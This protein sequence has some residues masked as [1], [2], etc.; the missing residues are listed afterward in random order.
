[1]TSL[2]Q[3]SGGLSLSPIRRR[4]ILD[5]CTR[6]DLP[7]SDVVAHH[8][9]YVQVSTPL[10]PGST[11]RL[12]ALIAADSRV[13]RAVQTAEQGDHAA[14]ARDALVVKVVPRPGTISPWS[15]KATDILHACGVIEVNRIERGTCYKIIPQRGWLTDKKLQDSQLKMLAGLLH[16]RMSES[17]FDH[18]FNGEALF[19]GRTGQPLQQLEFLTK[20]REALVH[21]N[22]AWALGLADEEIAHLADAYGRLNRNPTDVELIMFAQANSE[23]CRHKIFNAQWRIDGMEQR[24]SLFDMIRA[25]HRA[26]PKGTVVAY[27]DNAAVMEGG[28]VQRFSAAQASHSSAYAHQEAVEHTLMKVETHNH[29]TAIAPYPGAATGAGGEIRDEGATGR[30]ASPRV[31]L[32]GFT[33]SHLNLPQRTEP[34]E[35]GGLGYPAHTVDALTILREGS[36]GGAAYNNEFGRP[37]VLGY[38]RSFEQQIDG[39]NWGYHKPIMLA[40]GMGAIDSTQTHKNPIREG[41]LLIQIG[42]PG[43]RIGMGGG[44]ASSQSSG[45]TADQALDFD[46]VQ[47]E[48][49]ELQRR[50]QELI[51]RCW[52][53]GEANPIIAIHDVG[54][55]GLSNAFPEL[56]HDAGMGAIFDLALVP[57]AETGLSPAEVWSNEAQE[58]YVLAVAPQDIKRFDKLARRERCPYAVIGVATKEQQLRVTI[59]EGLPGLPDP[60][61]GPASERFRN[62]SL[63]DTGVRP[64]DLP[65]DVI[66]GDTPGL[67]MEA[68]SALA[69]NAHMDL[70]AIDLDEA[71]FRVLR[72]PTVASKSFLITG[73]D[74]TAGAFTARDQMVGPW[75]V[76]VADCAVGTADYASLRGQAMAMGERTPLAILNAPA[77]GR[78]AVAEALTNLAAADVRSMADIKLSANWMAAC[79]MPGQDAALYATVEAVSQWCQELGLSIP[80]GK[81]S[82]SMRLAWQNEGNE[83]SVQSPVSLVVTAFARVADVSRTLTPQLRTDAGDTVL[84]LIDLGQ[85]HQRLAGS[86]LMHAFEQLGD[87]TPDISVA[88]PLLSFFSTIRQLVDQE[89][90]L[91]YHDRSDGGLLA[92]VAEMAFAGRTGVSLNLDMLTFDP[93]VSDWGDYK[94][95]ANQVSVQRHEHT[96]KALFNEEAGAVLQV[97]RSRRDAVL[98]HLRQ[99]GLSTC[100]HV[101]GTLNENHEFQVYRDGQCLVRHPM[102]DLAQHWGQLSCDMAA[103]DGNPDAAKQEFERWKQDDAGLYSKLTF[104]P[105]ENIFAPFVGQGTRPRVGIL[106]EQGSNG[107]VEMAWAFDQAGFEAVDIHMSDLI[108]GNVQ[109]DS[110]KGLAVVGGFSWGDVFGA[111]QAWAQI[112]L[113]HPALKEQ[114]AAYFDREDTFALGVCNGAQMLSGLAGIIPGSSHW[115]RFVRNASQRYEA[116]LSMVGVAPSPSLF[117]TDMQGS[118][119]PVVVSHGE[120]HAW[121]DQPSDIEQAIVPLRYLDNNGQP[122][123]AY[124]ANPSGSPDGVAAVSSA[125]GRVLVMMPHAERSLRNV[126][127]SW[128]PGDWRKVIADDENAP[129]GGF[130][131]WMRMFQNARVWVG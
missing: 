86:I 27:A 54:A 46:S 64:V 95:Y 113:S 30:G 58:R 104:D 5:D 68:T 21:A 128:C 117:F 56:V 85:G 92:T 35:A 76:P 61:S 97:R 126:T 118:Q 108:D 11:E 106:R 109:L 48:N 12:Q 24:S 101:I 29:P 69:P 127:M 96:L 7:V 53:Q 1:M 103:L 44:A 91:A 49:P 114:F 55:G 78:M 77:S 89:D 14:P 110:L 105:S 119:L 41:D 57:V 45:T 37:N 99:A 50:A 122:T 123:T 125:D 90:I 9:Y 79:G 33:V 39:I 2:L 17:V 47:R 13:A 40:G 36:Q 111:G 60:A 51:S 22:S 16:D 107:Q 18:T 63:I 25:T 67:F 124:P 82:L 10:E 43:L 116:R 8:E 20:G 23:H 84:I 98:G 15:S 83:H 71:I 42:G 131:P 31:G 87:A 3:F 6:L 59:G 94:I 130:T 115:P 80:V 72:H 129:Q 93:Q 112:I 66:L 38:L 19:E 74:R 62:T 102:A 32:T 121:F 65:L 120:G 26:Q 28:T 75:Q 52:Q 100:S 73:A 81:D 88:A 34:W 70:T 4:Q